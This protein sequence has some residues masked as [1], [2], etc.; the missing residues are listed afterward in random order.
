MSTSSLERGTAMNFNF[1]ARSTP[2]TYVPAYSVLVARGHTMEEI[3]AMHLVAD[4]ATMRIAMVEA[5]LGDSVAREIAD[6]FDQEVIDLLVIGYDPDT[7]SR[8]TNNAMRLEKLR[9][10]RDSVGEHRLTDKVLREIL[11]M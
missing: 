9:A 5:G 2:E 6:R 10:W 7:E 8:R 11:V 4:R 3:E 1:N